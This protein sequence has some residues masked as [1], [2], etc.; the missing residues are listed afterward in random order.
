M[1][2][3]YRNFQHDC[4]EPHRV[5]EII[6][7][8]CSVLFFKKTSEIKACE[9]T[10]RIIKEHILRAGIAC[11]D[12]PVLWAGMPIIY[13]C[14][15]LETWIGTLPCA[16]DN[17]LPEI[18]SPYRSRMPAGCPLFKLPQLV[19]F[20]SFHEGVGHPHGI[21]RVLS[22]NGLV[23][24]RFIMGIVF[25]KVK[26]GVSLIHQRK[27]P[28]DISHRNTTAHG[29][30]DKGVQLFVLVTV[31]AVFNRF[32]DNRFK[33]PGA[34]FGSRHQCSNLVL[35]PC[36]PLDKLFDVGM[37]YVDNN[38]LCCPSSRPPRFDS[39]CSGIKNLQEAHQPGRTPPAA[40]FFPGRTKV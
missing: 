5:Q 38:H 22:C 19:V 37:I 28:D 13:C 34:D 11:I 4:P 36:L 23:C 21:I 29:V 24:F 33:E 40:K 8:Y 14:I 6:N 20:N 30:L 18:T 26:R 1:G 39:S 32:I 27:H 10:G 12:A 2:H 9:V 15:E 17:F 31:T 35:F 16:H 3:Q 7:L 25:V